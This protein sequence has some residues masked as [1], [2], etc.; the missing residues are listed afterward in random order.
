MKNNIEKLLNELIAEKTLQIN[1]NAENLK[2][3]EDY[4]LGVKNVND[5]IVENIKLQKKEILDLI[6]KGRLTIELSTILHS[7]LNNIK[8]IVFNS[9]KD[10][11]KLFYTK[12]GELISL[13][14]ELEKLKQTYHNNLENIKLDIN[15]QELLQQVNPD[16]NN[17]NHKNVNDNLEQKEDKKSIRLSQS[18]I[19]KTEKSTVK[20]IQKRKSNI[21]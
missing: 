21:K 18:S 5:K 2:R 10:G 11:E 19:T 9:T 15:D 4:C 7:V 17:L 8:T 3:I 20:H 6:S 13:K 1:T 16:I 12:Q 14:Q